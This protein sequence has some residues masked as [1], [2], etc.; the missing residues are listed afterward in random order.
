MRKRKCAYRKCTKARFEPRTVWQKFCTP[1]CSAME[2]WFRRRDRLRAA[3]KLH[4]E[5][6]NELGTVEYLG[7]MKHGA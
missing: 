7:R 5:D 6:L 3:E 1:Q 2:R 4:D